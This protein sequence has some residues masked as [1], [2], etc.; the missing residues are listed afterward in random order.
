[1]YPPWAS[2]RG[3]FTLRGGTA[4]TSLPT[5][6]AIVGILFHPTSLISLCSS[7][8]GPLLLCQILP[9]STTCSLRDRD[10]ALLFDPVGCELLELGG[11]AGTRCLPRRRRKKTS[12]ITNCARLSQ[13][14]PRQLPRLSPRPL[15]H[16]VDSWKHVYYRRPAERTGAVQSMCLLFG[17]RSANKL[18]LPRLSLTQLQNDAATNAS[19]MLQCAFVSAPWLNCG[20]RVRVCET[21][22]ES[23]AGPAHK[24]PSPP[25]TFALTGHMFATSAYLTGVAAL[26]LA[27]STSTVDL[28]HAAG[29][30]I[31]RGRQLSRKRDPGDSVSSP[32]SE[33]PHSFLSLL[34]LL[35]FP[36]C[37]PHCQVTIAKPRCMP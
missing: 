4:R 5:A 35:A 32:T 23:R 34:C 29:L 22:S 28:L 15:A 18:C 13:R 10:A 33:P 3:I 9:G 19:W 12:H 26:L 8:L 21:E 1:M 27:C 30:H 14:R 25:R 6:R 7:L 2:F 31:V 37:T 11:R 16:H 36:P 24:S 20:V 17:R